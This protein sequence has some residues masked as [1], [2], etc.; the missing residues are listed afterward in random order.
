MDCYDLLKHVIGNELCKLCVGS[1]LL[2]V[3]EH[4]GTWQEVSVPKSGTWQ[5][6]HWVYTPYQRAQ[7]CPNSVA[8]DLL[9]LSLLARGYY[10][11]SRQSSCVGCNRQVGVP[12]VT[13]PQ[14]TRLTCKL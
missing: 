11:P 14:P 4:N 1:P 2:Q 10:A 8:C 7:E 6:L 3:L 13:H 5:Q 12:K 9:V